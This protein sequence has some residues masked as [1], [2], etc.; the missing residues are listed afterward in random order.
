[1]ATNQVVY[2]DAFQ[3]RRAVQDGRTQTSY[4]FLQLGDLGARIHSRTLVQRHENYRPLAP[5]TEKDDVWL[6]G[7]PT[8]F[9]LPDSPTENLGIGD[10]VRFTRAYARVPGTQV[11][12][13]GSRYFPLPVVENDYGDQSAIPVFSYPRVVQNGTGTYNQAS[14]AIFISKLRALFGAAKACGVKVCGYATGG[15]FTLTYGANTTGALN[16]NDSGPTIATALNALASV[17]AAGLT[18]LCS[19][20]LNTVT[21]GDLIIQ[22]TAGQTLTPVTMNA[23][24]LTVTTST[25]PSTQVTSSQQQDIL[26]PDHITITAHSLSAAVQ[27][28]KVKYDGSEIF[29]VDVGSWGV[30]DANTI[31]TSADGVVNPCVAVATYKTT[32]VPGRGI[33]LRT[34]LTEKFYL[35]GRPGDVVSADV[36][37]LT[38]GLQNPSDFLAAVLTLTGWQTY[39]TEGPAFWLG[40][41]IYRV[42]ETAINLSDVP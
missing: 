36:I 33:L 19:N 39:E 10:L 34:R 2:D 42:A 1:M 26:L 8:A 17:T 30:I 28:A 13:P 5:G 3:F 6:G 32:Y 25:N 21:G 37:P 35:P 11:S 18:A 24:S 20:T 9:N 12:Y 38:T 7:D 14:G 41:P 23:G 15:T 16:W 22:W 4:P 29:V 31:W 27:L 40:G